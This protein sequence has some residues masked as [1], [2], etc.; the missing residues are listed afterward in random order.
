MLSVC[1]SIGEMLC[2]WYGYCRAARRE[3][4]RG[5]AL[6]ATPFPDFCCI[7]CR[8]TIRVAV[9]IDCWPACRQGRRFEKRTECW[10]LT[11]KRLDVTLKL[12]L[13]NSKL[14]VSGTAGLV[15]HKLVQSKIE[16]VSG[17][18]K[19]ASADDVPPTALRG[20]TSLSGS[21]VVDSRESG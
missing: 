16:V 20:M 13:W 15:S 8:S 9:E 3:I 1:R 12:S 11:V 18:E 19:E 21:F 2:S 17:A 7:G 5:G 14:R 4:R 10:I 6:S